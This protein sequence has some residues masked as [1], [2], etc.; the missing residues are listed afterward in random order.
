M[1]CPSGAIVWIPPECPPLLADL[2][3]NSQGNAGAQPNPAP[4]L[5]CGFDIPHPE[6]N[7]HIGMTSGKFSCVF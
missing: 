3:Q 2:D 5:H 7:S 4:N 6:F 1:E